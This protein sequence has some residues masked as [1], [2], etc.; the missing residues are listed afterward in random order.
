MEVKGTPLEV[1]GTTEGIRDVMVVSET[2]GKVVSLFV[3][4]GRYVSKGSVLVKVDDE[5]KLI[6]LNSAKVSYEKAKKDM[7]RYEEL[8]KEKSVSE[9]QYEGVRLTF[10]K[11]EIDYSL[12]KRQLE[13][14]EIK[15]PISGL[16]TTFNLEIGEMLTLGS[17]VANVVDLSALRVVFRADERVVF[18][19]R[20]GDNVEVRTDVYPNEIYN[21][22]IVSIGSKADVT[23]SYPVEV[24]FSNKIEKSLRAGMFV[25]GVFSVNQTLSRILIPASAI[26]G[27]ISSPFVFV[28][29]RG[30]ARMRNIKKGDPIGNKME[31]LE[32]L[33][34]GEELITTGL[35]YLKDGDKYELLPKISPPVV[36]IITVY[37]GGGAEEVESSVTK[38][39][40]DQ[41]SSVENL[42]VVISSSNVGLS[43]ITLQFKQSANVREAL[44]EV[45]R[46]LNLI[47]NDLPEDSEE[48][49]AFR[50][51]FDELPVLR[52]G[53]TSNMKDVDFFDLIDKQIKP[54]IGSI[55]GVGQVN[56]VGG[57]KREIRVNMSKEKLEFYKMSLGQVVASIMV[58]NLDFPTGVVKNMNEQ[59]TV[60]ISG[61][62]SSVDVLKELVMLKVPNGG[63]IRLKDVAEITDGAE[64]VSQY[65][66]INGNPSIG[67]LVSKQ[68]DANAVEVSK[69]VREKLKKLEQTYAAQSLK[70]E[71]GQD[72]SQFTLDAANSV[73]FDLYFAIF[74]VGMT[75]L[76]FLHS[77]RNAVIVMVSIPTSLLTTFIVMYILGFSLN[78]MTLLAYSLV[79]GILVDDSIVVLENIY[80]FLEKGTERKLAALMGRN[81]IGFTAVA[82]TMVDVVV[83]V[84]LS[85]VSGIIGNIMREF[86]IVMMFSTLVSLLV[87]FMVTPALASRI[88]KLERFTGRTLWEKFILKFE[89]S[90]E[91][92]LISYERLLRWSLC[93]KKVVALVALV[94]FFS[95]FLLFTGGFIGAEF[96]TQ[97]DRGE[98]SVFI[99]TAG[100]SSLEGTNAIAYK[101]EE[102]F[103][104]IPEI[105]RVMA[106][107]GVSNEG[108]IS[109]KSSN[110]TEF[111][112]LLVPKNKRKKSTD[113]V[114][115][116]IKQRLSK[117][118]GVKYRVSPIGIFG[119]ANQTPIQIVVMNPSRDSAI[120]AAKQ[121][122]KILQGIQGTS[123]VRSSA[124]SRGTDI[125]V[126]IDREKMASF[127]LTIQDIGAVMRIAFAGDDN[128]KFRDKGD[129]YA[130]RVTLKDF[131]KRN[132]EDVKNLG[133]RNSG[134]E[135]IFLK[136][137]AS[138]Y[139]TPTIPALQRYSRQNYVN[140][141]SQV[142]GGATSGAI[143]SEFE[144]KVKQV[145]IPERTQFDYLGDVK[146]QKDSDSNL[147]LAMFAAIFFM[148]L[149]MVLLYDSYLYPFIVLFT[150][151]LAT[152]G[153]FYALAISGSSINVFSG[154]GLIVLIGLVGKNAILLVDFANKLITDEG[155]PLVEAL[156]LAGKLRMRPILMTTIAL[157]AGLMPIAITSGAGAEWKQGL[158]WVIIGGLISS[159]ILTL[160]VIPSTFM[161]FEEWKQRTAQYFSRKK[162]VA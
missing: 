149:V 117:F 62:I 42:D 85:L 110:I 15:S 105:E 113:D 22:K 75:M 134:G 112:I 94:S 41:V 73:K 93:H 50:F 146:N 162:Q 109:G 2:Q 148:Y 159:T 27:E 139:Q 158:A 90:Y 72:G 137:F 98:F 18:S 76:L 44:Q 24:E 81:D 100:S 87:S 20:E 40:E 58:A 9:A 121:V 59:F 119:T 65:N 120:V 6:A 126:Q 64:D 5:L 118:S 135:Y 108:L 143:A 34:D 46:L 96:I 107:V 140:V 83:F 155:K 131:D 102:M 8:F 71:I 51:A 38:V 68:S 147:G 79:I 130:I 55:N 52:L 69:E 66:R 74:L 116:D 152:I 104:E 161:K 4:V 142:V 21:G 124:D 23:H 30:V 67:L 88:S 115:I 17:V 127:G 153:A 57:T 138:V 86:A 82:I 123:D 77:I 47:K 11:A 1:V 89:A 14:T 7:E 84:P 80:R 3:K 29:D 103:K 154:V 106:N 122:V 53:V 32:G 141:G 136:Q 101:V 10:A 13:D 26:F 60:R 156:V 150:I 45:E 63:E 16:V 25:R 157:V 61:K 132:I 97:S 125:A 99:E 48:P 31:V 12:A 56:I 49:K 145:K 19:L 91:K 160:V 54:A 114:V 70:F 92:M 129:E 28:Y 128:S 39:I 151:P 43:T 95:S 36:S 33:L 35:V 111:N 78:L 37:P 133:F 144:K